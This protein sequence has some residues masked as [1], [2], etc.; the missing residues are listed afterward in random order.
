MQ[1]FY[2]YFGVEKK[3][4]KHIFPSIPC[5]VTMTTQQRHQTTVKRVPDIT[6][7]KK[8]HDQ[9]M[10]RRIHMGIGYEGEKSLL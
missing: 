6:T 1:F 7:T 8:K 2:Y 4:E 5:L 9:R 10:Y 3:W